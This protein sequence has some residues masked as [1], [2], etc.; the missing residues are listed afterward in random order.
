MAAATTPNPPNPLL[1][2]PVR[3]AGFYVLLFSLTIA[4]ALN[5]VEATRGRRR[6]ES[7]DH[8]QGKYCRPFT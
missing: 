1:T 5:R 8:G 2:T 3:Q 7:R 6:R 4:V